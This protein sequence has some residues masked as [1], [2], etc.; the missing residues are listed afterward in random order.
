MWK[1]RTELNNKMPSFI[2]PQVVYAL[3][4]LVGTVVGFLIK[5]QLAKN[6]VE[7]KAKER[8]AKEESASSNYEQ[9]VANDTATVNNGI[10]KANHAAQDWASKDDP[11]P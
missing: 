2:T 6:D 7:I 4:T 10:S 11:I 9:H 8:L 3:I 1:L 5:Q